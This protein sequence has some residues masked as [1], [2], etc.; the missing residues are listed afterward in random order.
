MPSLVR[1]ASRS[2]AH[3]SGVFCSAHRKTAK[4]HHAFFRK[5]VF[6]PQVSILHGPPAKWRTLLVF[7]HAVRYHACMNKLT[8]HALALFSGGLDSIL[9]ARLVQDQGITVRCLHFVSP[10]F[11]KPQL[12][13]HWESSYGLSIETVDISDD[14]IR[15]LRQRPEHGF[16][17]VMNPCVDCKIL[18]MRRAAA[19]LRERNA[20]FLIS[21]EV[22]GQRP[23]S[24]RRDTLN[25]IRRDGDVRD[26]LL[27]P[28]SAKL[29]DPTAAERDGLVDRDRLLHFSGR[30][31]RSQLELAEQM[32]ITE[33][34][35]PG[36]GC[37]LAEK[38]NARRY[39]PVLTRLPEPASHDFE[40][41]N[42][43]RQFWAGN[44]WLALGR[45][46]SD[47]QALE[48][49]LRPGDM[50]FRLRDVT[51][52]LGLAR[53][54]A[55]S[56]DIEH[57]RDAASLVA[58]YAPRAVQHVEEHGGTVAVRVNFGN[59]EEAVADVVPTRKT[60]FFWGMPEFPEVREA[61]RKE[62]ATFEE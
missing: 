29:L 23:M 3:D 58:S 10:F 34:P 59:G 15:M 32:G 20:S 19:I 27:R 62:F 12:V 35:T 55:G 36:G 46:A 57:A 44:H 2:N 45:N 54:F 52:P 8:P 50:L 53:P 39:W 61:I 26:I 25:V 5:P 1:T 22:V 41:A 37:K 24:Q 9:A 30:G 47:N 43:G 28:L 21:G 17:K 13:P 48:T 4:N 40:L 18:M 33:I 31:R 16:G 11:G 60:A 38:E 49:L 56:W 14:Y 7:K 6:L 51:G 42:V